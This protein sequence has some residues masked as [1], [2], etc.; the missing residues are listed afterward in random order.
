MLKCKELRRLPKVASGKYVNFR[1]QTPGCTA[2]HFV[3]GP[4]NTLRSDYL[5]PSHPA[6]K[7]PKN[8]FP[9]IRSDILGVKAVPFAIL[10][11]PEQVWTTPSNLPIDTWTER[12]KRLTNTNANLETGQE[13][14]QVAPIF[15]NNAKKDAIPMSFVN[16]TSKKRTSNKRHVRGKIASRL[17]VAINLIVTRGADVVTVDGKPKL[18]MNEEEAEKM[19]DKWV[20]P[21][22]TY[23]FFPTL[24]IYRMPYHDMI[25]LLRDSLQRIY[26]LS[27]KFERKWASGTTTPRKASFTQ[28]SHYT[29]SHVEARRQHTGETTFR[30]PFQQRTPRQMTHRAYSTRSNPTIYPGSANNSYDAKPSRERNS[31]VS[32]K[33]NH[34]LQIFDEPKPSE[35]SQSH[36][37]NEFGKTPTSVLS[38]E[39]VK[40]EDKPGTT[41]TIR[42]GDVIFKRTFPVSHSSLIPGSDSPKILPAIRED[43]SRTRMLKELRSDVTQVFGKSAQSRREFIR[44]RI[45]F[46][47]A[48]RRKPLGLEFIGFDSRPNP[49]YDPFTDIEPD[50][51]PEEGPTPTRKAL[52]DLLNTN[53]AR[54]SPRNPEWC[55]LAEAADP[56]LSDYPSENPRVD[57]PAPDDFD[58]FAPLIHT[59]EITPASEV[60]TKSPDKSSSGSVDLDDFVPLEH[61]PTPSA[62]ETELEPELAPSNV[63]PGVTR[64]VEDLIQA[65]DPFHPEDVDG[66][67]VTTT[68]TPVSQATFG[69]SPP[70]STLTKGRTEERDGETISETFAPP[71]TKRLRQKLFRARPILISWDILR[72]KQRSRP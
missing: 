29:P 2:D 55:A 61:T 40:L 5:D 51:Q 71:H 46:Q 32:K 50:P 13:P 64:S 36:R 20:S 4:G 23:I 45:A 62:F 41:P 56:A 33:A 25:P 30:K 28:H 35:R 70:P 65:F 24:E 21:G 44:R 3:A 52:L 39:T 63:S 22:W 67:L 15:L 8:F 49:S 37:S 19:S 7:I 12:M 53:S 68:T 60:L 43:D 57:P 59:K 58:P 9:N 6:T 66:S 17:K 14:L 31:N 42:L 69:P 10:T 16:A 38:D 27:Q 34:R 47:Q 26:D 72:Q 54:T 1:R 48:R 18:V 11:K